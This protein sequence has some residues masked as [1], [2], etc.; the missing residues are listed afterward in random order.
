MCMIYYNRIS[1]T[2][3]RFQVLSVFGPASSAN[4]M[5]LQIQALPRTYCPGI[6][7]TK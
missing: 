6:V 2:P 4:R 7:W 3:L 1:L 5:F